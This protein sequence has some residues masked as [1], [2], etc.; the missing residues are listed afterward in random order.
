[1]SPVDVSFA[2]ASKRVKKSKT[3]K[4]KGKKSKKQK[5]Q[6][7]QSPTTPG[8]SQDDTKESTKADAIN[9]FLE[10]YRGVIKTLPVC[11]WPTSTKHGQHSYTV[12]L[13]KY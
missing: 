4:G 13:E 8:A 11:M 1:M 6:K 7:K 5:K 9:S 3:K 12:L 2:R 10:V